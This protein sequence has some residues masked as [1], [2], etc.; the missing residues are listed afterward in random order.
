MF[1]FFI[2]VWAS[3]TLLQYRYGIIYNLR[4]RIN[5][6]EKA[7]VVAAVWGIEFMRSHEIT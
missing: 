5:I 2:V 3:P 4:R 7:K 6:E 1:F